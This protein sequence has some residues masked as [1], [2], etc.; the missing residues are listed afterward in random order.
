MFNAVPVK[1]GNAYASLDKAIDLS[2]SFKEGLLG[3]NG[4]DFDGDF[5]FGGEF[6]AKIDLRLGSE[7]YSCGS[8]ILL[9]KGKL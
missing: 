5:F 4:V 2:L 6:I 8:E 1:V 3:I 7:A 9:V